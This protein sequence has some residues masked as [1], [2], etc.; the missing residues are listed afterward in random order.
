LEKELRSSYFVIF[1]TL[2][3]ALLIATL[4][5]H[6][7]RARRSPDTVWEDMLQRLTWID[8]IAIATIALDVVSESGEPR[9]EGDG[10]VLDRAAIWRL[11]GGLEGLEIIEHNCKILVELA[12]Y[13]QRWY[14]EA[15]VVAEHL[16]L[17][18]REIEWHVGRLKG[19]A[20]TGN[21]DA[22]FADYAQSA[23][24]IY[25]RMT[26]QLLALYDQASFP[27]LAELQRAI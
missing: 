19:A 1:A 22:A 9:T 26:R 24:A 18:A 2:L 12:A 21:L 13:L 16:R 23:V 8:R 5:Y 3:L 20:K 14:P 15:L 27:R 11:L 4:L 25:Y 17:N 7:F 6:H 10:F